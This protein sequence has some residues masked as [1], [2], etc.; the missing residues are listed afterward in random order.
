MAET[1]TMPK[2]GFDMAEGMLV[3]W[4]KKQGDPVKKGDVIAEIETDKATVEVESPYE[5]M[6]LK[7]LV[8]QS[9]SVP[10]GDPIAVIGKEGEV[11]EQVVKTKPTEPVLPVG[12]P[13]FPKVEGPEQKVDKA[14]PMNDGEVAASPL[15]RKVAR[16]TGIDLQNVQ[17]SGPNGRVIRKDVEAYQNE[18]KTQP[19][20]PGYSPV[21]LGQAD[22]LIPLN[23]LRGAIG[24]R[25]VESKT[26]VPHF[27]VTHAYQAD[28]MMELRK[29]INQSLPDDERLSVN[30]FIV[31]AT[32]LA[33]RVFPALNGS[34]SGN[35]II[36]HQG[37]HIGV[38][39]AVEG[40]LLTVVVRNADKKSL[41]QISSEVKEMATRVKQGKVKPDDVE[42]STFSISNLGMFDVEAFSAI[43]NPPEA[44]ILAVASVHEAP[45]VENGSLRMGQV[46]NATLSVDHRISD[47]VE[48]AR[49][50]QELE[51]LIENPLLM[52]I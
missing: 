47:G 2:L 36:Q 30:D 10:V 26:T 24:R 37:I 34:I 32:A 13:T 18:I 4:V 35:E 41:S 23:K 33:L 40:G 1:V 9:T 16:D 6:M 52:L 22:N 5:G 14:Q 12:W 20:K 25:M 11:V 15:A 38:A 51:R 28:R 43:I 49:F 27:Y 44:A 29:Q 42:G 3:R 21:S 19:N 8:E 46:F 7:H 39:V 50:M 17:G 31:K 45:V 48:A